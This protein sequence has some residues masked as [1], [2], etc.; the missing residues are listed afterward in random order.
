MSQS[1][2]R[3]RAMYEPWALITSLVLLYEMAVFIVFIIDIQ[4][5]SV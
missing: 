1:T 5:A 3:K 2:K 4:Y